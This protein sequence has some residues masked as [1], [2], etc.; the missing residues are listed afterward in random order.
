MTLKENEVMKI[1]DEE[2]VKHGLKTFLLIGGTGSKLAYTSL[3]MLP[4]MQLNSL[5]QAKASVQESEESY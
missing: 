5:M 2:F 3:Y 4:I 1:I